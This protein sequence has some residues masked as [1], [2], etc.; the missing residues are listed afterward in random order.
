[1]SNAFFKMNETKHP[2]IRASLEIGKDLF[3]RGDYIAALRQYR[4]AL[5]I[6][7][8]QREVFLKLAKL[9]M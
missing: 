4:K 8:Y 5:D 6:E 7:I 9:I 2:E 3:L 1:M